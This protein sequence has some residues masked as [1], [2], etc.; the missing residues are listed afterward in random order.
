VVLALAGA[1]IAVVS[2]GRAAED[3]RYQLAGLADPFLG[4]PAPGLSIVVG[5]ILS[6]IL[7]AV[8]LASG[9]VTRRGGPTVD[10]ADSGV[11]RRWWWVWLLVAAWGGYAAGAAVVTAG[12]G[13]VSYGGSLHTE[14]GA[15]LDSSA[16]VGVTCRSVVGEPGLVAQVIP[17]VDGLPMLDLRRVATGTTFEWLSPVPAL[18]SSPGAR[19]TVFQPPGVPDRP[20][21]YLEAKTFEGI[22][23]DPPISFLGAYDYRVVALEESGLSGVARLEGVRFK[24][25]YRSPDLHWVNL[26][27][28]NDPWPETFELTLR[29]TCRAEAAVQA[30]DAATTLPPASCAEATAGGADGATITAIDLGTLGGASSSAR[31]INDQGQ[32]VGIADTGKTYFA[33]AFMWQDGVM[34]DLGTL[35]GDGSWATAVN[36]RGEVAGY[37]KVPSADAPTDIGHVHA[38]L[39]RDG[40]MTDLGSLGGQTIAVTDLNEEGQ[41]VGWGQT[42]S[43]EIHA[44]LWH[45]GVMT[46]LGTLGGTE[47]QALGINESGQVVGHSYTGAPGMGNAFLWQDGVMTDLGTSGGWGSSAQAINDEGDMA[48]WVSEPSGASRSVLWRDRTLVELGSVEGATRGVSALNNRGHVVGADAFGLDGPEKAFL[49]QDGTTIDLGALVGPWSEAYAVNDCGQVVGA[50]GVARQGS[51]ATWW[52]ASNP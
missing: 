18:A 37:S 4:R 10:E 9:A 47:S 39:W 24:D 42:A 35:G 7:V 23:A 41:V 28:A 8:V 11:I 26:E 32:V 1:G 20:A 52:A 25:P 38:F 19:G 33:H 27:I 15:P 21:P 48:G 46:D 40:T 17:A 51:H 49:W 44:F 29:W 34:T 16:D 22:R 5:I 14:Y 31:D 6:T 43:G 12:G 3:W 2:Y 30:L 50:S 45:G 13:P 36:E